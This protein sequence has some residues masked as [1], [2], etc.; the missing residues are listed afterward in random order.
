VLFLDRVAIFKSNMTRAA[1]TQLDSTVGSFSTLGLTFPPTYRSFSQP[2][3]FDLILIRGLPLLF[4]TREVSR[5]G[6]QVLKRKITQFAKLYPY[7]KSLAAVP[8]N[9]LSEECH[10]YVTLRHFG[11]L[12][13]FS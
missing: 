2:I 10:R 8:S 1:I 12:W 7:K 3:G 9:G 4:L 6:V 13:R 11:L 5:F